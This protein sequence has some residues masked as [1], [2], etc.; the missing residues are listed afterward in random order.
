MATITLIRANGIRSDSRTQKM[1]TVLQEIDTVVPIL[2]YR[3]SVIEAPA[4]ARC[5]HLPV[6]LGSK[7]FYLA[8]PVWFLY[9]FVQLWQIRPAVIQ[10]MDLEGVLPAIAYRFFHPT[11]KVI[12][13][14]FDVTAGK[15]PLL[16]LKNFFLKLDRSIIDKADSCFI[17]DPDRIDQLE[18]PAN[19]RRQFEEK[20]VVT[21][22]SES[23][24]SVVKEVTLDKKHFE[25]VYVGHLIQRIRGIEQLIQAAQDFPTVSF[26]IAGAGPDADYFNRQITQLGLPNLRYLGR[27]SHDQAM[28][29]N[30]RA[31]LMISLLDPEYPNY[32]YA[33]STKIFEAMHLF[34]PIITTQNTASGRIVEAINWGIVVSYDYASFKKALAELTAGKLHFTL[35]GKKAAQYSWPAMVERIKESYE[36][37]LEVSV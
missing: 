28:S 32:K 26:S 31:D 29:L 4:K 5:L 11:T 3:D 16:S 30:A 6:P 15:L 22:N 21:Y 8:F 37:L 34:K 14:I 10:G 12:F 13:D 23:V 2:W 20:C 1:Y 35:D 17:P 27:V 24:E 9:C 36:K 19:Q 18:V 7:L 33:S 25:I